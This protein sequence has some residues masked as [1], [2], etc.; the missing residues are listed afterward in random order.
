MGSKSRPGFVSINQSTVTSQSHSCPLPAGLITL[1]AGGDTR[2]GP[3]TQEDSPG[4]GQEPR[5]L[6]VDGQNGSCPAQG[7]LELE[8]DCCLFNGIVLISLINL[9]RYDLF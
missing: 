8:L 3:Q 6:R 7:W 9:D 4:D 2:P 1:F 5:I